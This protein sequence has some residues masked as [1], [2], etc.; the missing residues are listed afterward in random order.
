M[1]C[2]F[3]KNLPVCYHQIKSS[4]D[5]RSRSINYW[6]FRLLNYFVQIITIN[7]TVFILTLLF[8][9][10]P[11][12]RHSALARLRL[13]SEETLD[14]PG[15]SWSRLPGFTRT[16][17]TKSSNHF[18]KTYSQIFCNISPNLK[19][20]HTMPVNWICEIIVYWFIVNW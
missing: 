17:N 7:Y 8:V 20:C 3:E 2:T 14:G 13:R 16:I 15:S 9:L 19:Q 4:L 12:L 11:H 10:K 5:K 18:R 1:A 6:K